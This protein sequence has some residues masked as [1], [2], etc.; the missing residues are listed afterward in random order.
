MNSVWSTAALAA[1]SA[2]IAVAPEAAS[3]AVMRAAEIVLAAAPFSSA[4]AT[5]ALIS[6]D[7]TLCQASA[8]AGGG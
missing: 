1:I 6:A 8:V 4:M 3:S 2:A 5:R 7:L